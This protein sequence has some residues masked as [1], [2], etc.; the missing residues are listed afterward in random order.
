MSSAEG[1]PCDAYQALL[2]AKNDG[3]L[4]SVNRISFQKSGLTRIDEKLWREL[5]TIESVDLSRNLLKDF[6]FETATD[7]VKQLNLSFNLLPT[8]DFDHI[9]SRLPSLLSLD[10]SNNLISHVHPPKTALR[11]S[12]KVLIK[13]NPLVC[14]QHN[15]WLIEHLEK[16][17]PK[18]FSEAKC[19]QC[20][21]FNVQYSQ[22][23]PVIKNPVCAKCD[24]FANIREN[25]VILSV[26]CS[27]TGLTSMPQNLPPQTKVV[28]LAN[29]NIRDLTFDPSWSSVIYLHLQNNSIESL[30][31]LEGSLYV[32]N[33]RYLQLDKNRLTEVQAH[34][35]KHLNVDR[36]FL[37]ENPWR[38][39]CN[40]I[41]FQLWIQE[42][43]MKVADIEEVVCGGS[44][45]QNERNGRR[46]Q[47]TDN[48]VTLHFRTIYK[49]ARS[50]LCPQP[51]DGKFGREE[52]LD[53]FNV[54]ITVLIVLVILKTIY[55]WRWQRRTGKLPRFFKVNV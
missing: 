51:E 8:F 43:A 22:A 23:I 37:S 13:N 44:F 27:K 45:L 42:H 3:L 36:I 53:Y 2:D 30:K 20:S 55:D 48:E 38:C 33:L 35:L 17:S 5:L 31:G 50:D 39:D 21:L 4:R 7:R 25:Q 11:S 6:I 54:A 1:V 47:E 14:T 19:G 41:A 40:T 49:I 52:L 12:Q 46:S 16:T 15:L 10:I 29:N 9:I 28:S 32:P 26:N 24:C 18:D 34:V